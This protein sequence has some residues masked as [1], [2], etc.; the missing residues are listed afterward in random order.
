M[1]KQYKPVEGMK[2]L[3]NSDGK[4]EITY[5]WIHR[6]SSHTSPPSI[7]NDIP[8]RFAICELVD[9]PDATIVMTPERI[10]MLRSLLALAEVEEFYYGRGG[11]RA[12]IWAAAI[13][14]AKTLLA[15]L[16]AA[17]SCEEVER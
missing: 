3:L 5:N 2:T 15:E 1:M 16:E 8:E 12:E 17:D 7:Y 11:I 13:R 4:V 6:R 10:T 14:E 9:V